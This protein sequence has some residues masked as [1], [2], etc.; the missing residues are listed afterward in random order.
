MPHFMKNN[1]IANEIIFKPEG[2]MLIFNR[3]FEH[4]VTMFPQTYVKRSIKAV[5]TYTIC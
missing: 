5:N 3:S 2:N 1:A 4:C